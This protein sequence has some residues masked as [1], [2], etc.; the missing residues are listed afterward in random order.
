MTKVSKN[1]IKGLAK[2]IFKKDVS[3]EV[4]EAILQVEEVKAYL[5]AA[6]FNLAQVKQSEK[7][8]KKIELIDQSLI[9]IRKTKN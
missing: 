8:N 7:I 9:N 6:K 2:D 4:H 1:S 5:V 3:I